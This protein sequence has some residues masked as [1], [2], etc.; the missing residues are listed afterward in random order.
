[1]SK[2][3]FEVDIASNTRNINDL[4]EC[5]IFSI[6][7]GINAPVGKQW[8]TILVI[9][10]NGNLDYINQLCFVIDQARPYSRVRNGSDGTWTA[11]EKL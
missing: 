5:G 2:D 3:E 6:Y 1:M 4:N 8:C 9:R 7:D 11:W 10:Q